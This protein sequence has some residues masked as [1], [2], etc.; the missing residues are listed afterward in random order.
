MRRLLILP[1]LL[2][3]SFP[4][5]SLHSAEINCESQVWRNKEICIEK[6]PRKK[7]RK[8]D[9]CQQENLSPIQEEECLDFEKKKLEAFNK[10]LKYPISIGEVRVQN[11]LLKEFIP[12]SEERTKQ[13]NLILLQLRS[14]DGSNLVIAKVKSPAVCFNCASGFVDMEK[15]IIPTK[16][17]IGWSKKGET[18]TDSTSAKT[19]GAMALLYNPALIF[20]TPFGTTNIQN[21]Y[22]HIS[23]FDNQ[24][25][26]NDFYFQHVL[27][28]KSK[29][30]NLIPR[31]LTKISG[32]ES[33]E[34]RSDDELKPMLIKSIS[35]LEKETL[36]LEEIL[37]ISNS[38]NQKCLTLNSEK[39]PNM[40]EKYQSK[41]DLINDLK[42]K[43]DLPINDTKKICE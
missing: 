27:A 33:G 12:P 11:I 25:S 36:R 17:I 38:G 20:L 30:V 5:N 26:K 35:E 18:R 31:F 7:E 15:L 41:I 32:L 29:I 39:Y 24:G 1:L 2:G 16:N 22:Y 40:F 28:N 19:W 14:K 23:Y 9:F 10:P 43:L 8:P 4:T 3:V 37:T 42:F 13:N 34:L 6:K 21:D